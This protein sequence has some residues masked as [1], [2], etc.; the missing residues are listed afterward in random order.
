MNAAQPIQY[1]IVP[2]F[3]ACTIMSLVLTVIGILVAYLAGMFAAHLYFGINPRTFT[4]LSFVTWGDV[5]VGFSKAAAYG[6]AIPIISGQ[7]GLAAFGG[8]E[9]VG[10]ATTAAVVNA[11]LAVVILDFLISGLGYVFLP[12]I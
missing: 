2:R 7:A 12:G 5:I 8:S 10:W 1:L 9:G 4:N 11:S 6:M 3:I